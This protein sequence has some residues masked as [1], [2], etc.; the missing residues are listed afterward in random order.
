MVI[1]NQMEEIIDQCCL[2]KLTIEYCPV[3]VLVSHCNLGPKVFPGDFV[4]EF[5]S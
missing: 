4:D 1:V 3:L 2:W 5:S